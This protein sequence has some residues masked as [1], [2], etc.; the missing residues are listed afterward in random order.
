MVHGSG[1]RLKVSRIPSTTTHRACKFDPV[2]WEPSDLKKLRFP[3][4]AYD[5]K[6]TTRKLTDAQELFGDILDVKLKG[7]ARISYHLMNQYTHW[8]GLEG[9][10][11]DMYL[12]PQMLHDALAFLQEG[13]RHILQQTIDQNLLSLNNDSAYHSSGGNGY[14]DELPKSDFESTRVR[15]RDMWASAESQVLAQVA[16]SNTPS[17]R[18][19]MR[20]PCWSRLA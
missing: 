13:H 16:P 20:S 1:W 9:M 10:M 19:S 18:S 4:I 11:T 14:T 3:E 17:S 2:I 15:P 5:G 7:V 8:R 6:A 12:Q